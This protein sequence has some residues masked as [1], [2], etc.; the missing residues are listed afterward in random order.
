MTGKKSIAITILL[1]SFILI[2]ASASSALAGGRVHGEESNSWGKW[3]QEQGK[4]ASGFL[5]GRPEDLGHERLMSMRTRGA[6]QGLFGGFDFVN[7]SVKG[8]FVTFDLLSEPWRVVNYTLKGDDVEVSVF[9]AI[10]IS[11]FSANEKVAHGS[12]VILRDELTSALLHDNPTGMLSIMTNATNV[13]VS[14]LLSSGMVAV[15]LPPALNHSWS[16]AVVAIYGRGMMGIIASDGAEL[17]VETANARTFINV[18]LSHDRVMFRAK[19]LLSYHQAHGDVILNAITQG[20][21]AGEISVIRMYGITA[22]DAMHYNKGFMMWPTSS[23]NNRLR[24]MVQN[25][26]HTGKV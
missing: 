26:E 8:R 16:H 9:D 1:L 14:F 21:V 17:V 15:S 22:F 24:F 25:E 5:N 3:G 18:S 13:S 19:P 7:E 23:E 12:V 20:R 11:G 6:T 10:A 4:N 2:I